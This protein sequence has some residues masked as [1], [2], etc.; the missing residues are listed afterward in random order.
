VLASE[1]IYND[2][3]TV[4]SDKNGIVQ[5]TTY[6]HSTLYKSKHKEYF[7]LKGESLKV[8]SGNRWNTIVSG[9]MVLVKIE[10]GHE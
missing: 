10:V 3:M 5:V 6:M 8:R 4:L 2:I 7:K 1:R 9:D